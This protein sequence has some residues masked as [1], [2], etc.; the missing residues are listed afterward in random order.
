M[1]V[2]R[3]ELSVS[4]LHHSERP[5]AVVFQFKQK[6]GVI[7]CLSTALEW[8]GLEWKHRRENSKNDS[9]GATS[10]TGCVYGYC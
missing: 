10:Q 3:D 1:T 6:I 2:T 9:S 7:E 8:Y 5:D 4:G